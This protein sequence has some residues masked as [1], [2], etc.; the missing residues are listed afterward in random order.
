M[1]AGKRKKE[2][3]KTERDICD[4]RVAFAIENILTYLNFNTLCPQKN[5]EVCILV[6]TTFNPY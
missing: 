3:G 4:S 1:I 5:L 6:V 2:G